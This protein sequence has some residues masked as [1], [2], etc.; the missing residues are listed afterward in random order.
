MYVG[1]LIRSSHI[2][3]NQIRFTIV[4]N[5]IC[6]VDVCTVLYEKVENADFPARCGTKKIALIKV[7]QQRPA[8]WFTKLLSSEHHN[9]HVGDIDNSTLQPIRCLSYLHREE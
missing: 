7:Y 6:L 1:L 9:L 8:D 3:R 2:S 5:Q 4:T